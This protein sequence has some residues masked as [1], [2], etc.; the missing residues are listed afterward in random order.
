LRT[1]LGPAPKP[2]QPCWDGCRS[3][4]GNVRNG[5]SPKTTRTDVGEVRISVPRDRAGTFTPTVV[6]KHTRRLA[7]FNDAVLS[8]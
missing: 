3:G 7:G 8:L 4:S 1:K 2:G 6:P 5:S